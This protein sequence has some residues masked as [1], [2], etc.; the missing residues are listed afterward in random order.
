MTNPLEKLVPLMSVFIERHRL[1]PDFG[2][3]S[4]E[5]QPRIWRRDDPGAARDLIIELVWRPAGIAEC[6]QASLRPM[7]MTEIVQH[8]RC[9]RQCHA[10]VDVH[11]IWQ[12]VI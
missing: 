2:A 9:L 5:D 8:L 4:I 6:D 3:V 7:A 12:A 10:A 1:A 11:R